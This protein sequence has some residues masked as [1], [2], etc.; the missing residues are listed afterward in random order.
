LIPI[1][2]AGYAISES[3][4]ARR[5]GICLRVSTDTQTTEN[6]RREL[7]SVAA[8]SGWQ[9]VGFH[10]DAGVSGAKGRAKRPGFD[11]LLKDAN[12]RKLDVIAARFMD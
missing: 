7:E 3:G 8:R 10:E 1:L 2:G 11:R 12:G 5:V 6:Q 4:S 9:V